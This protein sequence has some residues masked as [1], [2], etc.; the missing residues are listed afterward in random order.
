MIRGFFLSF[1]IYFRQLMP[2]KVIDVHYDFM[3]RL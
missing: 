1:F 3:R 2:C